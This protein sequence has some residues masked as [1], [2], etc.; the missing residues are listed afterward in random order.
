MVMLQNTN[1]KIK[2]DAEMNKITQVVLFTS[3]LKYE[4]ITWEIR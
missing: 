3:Y 2:I 4:L 1:V